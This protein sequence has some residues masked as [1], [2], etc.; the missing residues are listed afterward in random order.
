MAKKTTALTTSSSRLALSRVNLR[1]SLVMRE[2]ADI[3]VSDIT[4]YS[5]TAAAD[6]AKIE[7]ALR[8]SLGQAYGFG[9]ASSD[10]A[11]KPFIYNDGVAIIPVHGALINRFGGSWGF[12][13]GYQ[14][15]R[16]MMN[17]AL[18]D[19][20]VKLLV[21]DIDSP[22][23]ES[24]GCFEL[25]NEIRQSRTIKPSMAVV[26]SLACSA[27]FAVPSSCTRMVATPSGRIGSIGVYRMHIDISGA[28][29]QAGVKITFVE[30]PEEGQKTAGNMFEPLSDDARKDAQ[31]SVNQTYDDFVN[32]V[33]ANRGISADAV[34]DT[35]AR[36][37]RADEAL[38]LGLI[39]AV[40]T[41]SEA[42]SS[43]LAELADDDPNEEDDEMSKAG[44]EATSTTTAAAAPA[45]AA[46]APAQPDQAAITSAVAT[47]LQEDRQRMS[48]IKALPEA[49]KR[50]KLAERL[51][52]DG[53]SVDQAKG[54]LEAAAE[55]TAAAPAAPAT[56]ESV[57]SKNHLAEVMDKSEHPNVGA[58]GDKSGENA[59]A[60]KSDADLAAAILADQG[61][62]IGRNFG[63]KQTA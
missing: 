8:E 5:Q 24:A 20:D 25:S 31:K 41:P 6:G 63:E 58:G 47:A 17:A 28:L 53:F 1:D 50:P 37:F 48:A 43:F 42:V 12:A 55:E 14:Y 11:R 51:A 10:S 36:V 59:G 21:F 9:P 54:L 45:S 46:P 18:E 57:D 13:T 23:G 52:L 15:I 35:Q 19:D 40:Q 16:R 22:G 49:A 60:P 3:F 62:V 7:A 34:R 4:Q 39:D 33:V 44:S 27:G 2:T 29:D 32:L 30:A 56:A 26:D 38:A 61:A